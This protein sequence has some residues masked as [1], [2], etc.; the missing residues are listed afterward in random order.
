M[1]LKKHITRAGR[2][3]TEIEKARKEWDFYT[4]DRLSGG[5][6]D[7]ISH[8]PEVCTREMESIRHEM[9]RLRGEL[10]DDGYRE[11][12]ETA[13]AA[14]GLSYEGTFP[15]YQIAPFKLNL[16]LS[17]GQVRLEFSRKRET[18]Y[19]LEPSAVAQWVKKRHTA[20]LKRPF[21]SKRFF[22]N[23]LSAYKVAN[24][25]AYGRDKEEVLW[26]KPVQLAQLFEL[27]TL[28]RETRKEYPKEYFIY[29]IARLRKEGL[30]QDGHRVEFGPSREAGR[31]FLVPSLGQTGNEERFSSLIIYKEG[32]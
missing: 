4:F 30:E 22:E 3:I 12:L 16:D 2:T 21:Q 32:S 11:K 18:K 13:L 17:M 31:T 14:A 6:P 24:R 1:E 29:D 15:N 9:E 5:L 20:L 10:R 23:L 27:L 25:L 28:R 19:K 26:G 8:L 7:E